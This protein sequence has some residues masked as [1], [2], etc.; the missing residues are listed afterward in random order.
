M[1]ELL[2]YAL[3]NGMIDL[4]H[5]QKELIMKKNNELLAKHQYS[6]WQGKDG[7]YYTYLPHE[8]K[9]RI[10]K[11]RNTQ[12]EI[13]QIVIDYQ[14]QQLEDPTIEEV[15]DEWNDRKLELKKIVPST[16]SR[17]QRIFNKHYCEIRKKRIGTVTPEY[18]EEFLKKQIPRY[19]LTAKAFSNLKTITRGFFKR[20]KKRKLIDFS[21]EDVFT[22]MELSDREFRKVIKEDYQEVFNEEETYKV[23]NYL[24]ANLDLKNIGILLMFVTG[25]RVGELVT[26]KHKD[27]DG[28]TFRVRRTEMRY[29]VGNGKSIYAVKEF[30]KTSAGLRTVIIPPDFEWIVNRL[31]LYNP[32]GDYV[33]V[34]QGKLLTTNCIRQRLRTICSKLNIYHKSPHKIRKTY[35][36]IL[37]DSNVDTRLI[38]DLM[39]HTSI[40][41]TEEHYHRNRKSIEKKSEILGSIPEF[42]AK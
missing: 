35:G 12:K 39:G 28:N 4:Q 15:F 42:Q 2:K 14:K 13:E 17:N 7:K 33:F 18:L 22:E 21:I 31:R 16:H 5:I 27:F 6:I 1:N 23:M 36:T 8:T 24:Y 30:P 40:L 3:E 19:Q 11:K 34:N 37:I 9:G 20:A 26:L 41:C 25:I 29:N 10:L 38:T 32:F